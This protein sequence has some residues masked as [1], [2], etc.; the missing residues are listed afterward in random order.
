MRKP[1]TLPIITPLHNAVPYSLMVTDERWCK[2]LTKNKNTKGK[3]GTECKPKCEGS[4]KEVFLQRSGSGV[5][6]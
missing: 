3:H 1:L 6:F 5:I 2:Q 4:E